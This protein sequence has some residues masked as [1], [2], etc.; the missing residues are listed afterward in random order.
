MAEHRQPGQRREDGGD[1]EVLVAGPELLD[2]GLLVRVAH[3]VHVPAEDRRVE[4]ERVPD[5]LA[6]AGAVLVPEHVH[7]RAVVDAVHPEGSD[8]VALHEPERLG[9]QERPG[10]LGRHPVHDL[11]PELVRHRRLEGR[12]REGVLGA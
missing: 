5:H 7:E 4:L 10:N 12:P 6:I 1:A 11:A 8:E 9:Q 2:R 3:E